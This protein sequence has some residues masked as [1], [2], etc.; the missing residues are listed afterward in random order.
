[1]LKPITELSLFLNLF[2]N[3]SKVQIDGFLY[4]I[5]FFVPWHLGHL[6]PSFFNSWKLFP[7][8]FTC[9]HCPQSS[10]FTWPDF[11]FVPQT[12]QTSFFVPLFVSLLF[13]FFRA[14]TLS[15]TSTWNGI[16]VGVVKVDRVSFF[17]FPI[18]FLFVV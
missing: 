7:T 14:G 11:V 4:Y 9:F 12:S 2:F 6:Y 15:F 17:F 1:M 16:S 3:I 8:H 13:F 18:F 10:H 5:Y